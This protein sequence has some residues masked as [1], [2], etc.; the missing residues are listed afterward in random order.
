MDKL[1]PVNLNVS[2]GNP[3]DAQER[4]K[5]YEKKAASEGETLGGW[6]RKA[7][8]KASGYKETK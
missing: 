6:A 2:L 8:D 4:R 1:K 5:Y 3:T 7:L